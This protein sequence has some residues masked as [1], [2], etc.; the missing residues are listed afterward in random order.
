MIE[1]IEKMVLCLAIALLLGFIIGWLFSNALHKKENRVLEEKE[2]TKS[3]N[4][5]LAR[6]HQ[7]E[8][9]YDEEKALALEYQTKNKKLKGELMKKI[10]LL[11]N[12]SETLKEIQHKNGCSDLEAKL[13]KKEQELKEFE[14]VLIK[15]EETIESQKS[16]IQELQKQ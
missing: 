1:I 4:E 8:K 7:L 10:N 6:I 15:A 2:E 9:L 12:T 3:D 11:S 14:E 5:L 16:L 13:A